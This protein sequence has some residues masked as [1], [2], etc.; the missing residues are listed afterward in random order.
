MKGELRVD[1]GGKIRVFF[2]KYVFWTIIEWGV[3]LFW[4]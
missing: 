1:F 4:V 3:E 2:E